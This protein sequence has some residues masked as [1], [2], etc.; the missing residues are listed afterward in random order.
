MSPQ[1][2]LRLYPQNVCNLPS[3]QG[4]EKTPDVS[5]VFHVILPS[6]PDTARTWYQ[7]T[8]PFGTEGG[9]QVARIL[10]EFIASTVGFD[11][12][13]GSVQ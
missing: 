10:V 8:G 2:A 9:T 4:P 13:D 1:M 3:E 11:I 12:L 6:F 7:L 5:V